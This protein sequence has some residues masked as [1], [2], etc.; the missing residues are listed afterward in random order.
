V[1]TYVVHQG[2]KCGRPQT[3]QTMWEVASKLEGQMVQQK[4]IDELAFA[5]RPRFQLQLYLHLE[6]MFEGTTLG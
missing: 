2:D 4:V 1:R 3:P 6:Q 5:Q